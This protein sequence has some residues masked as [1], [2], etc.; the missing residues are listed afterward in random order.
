ML[1][2]LQDARRTKDVDFATTASSVAEAVDDLLGLIEANL[3][4]Y[5]EYRFIRTSPILGDED[6]RDGIRLTFEPVFGGTKKMSW[7]NVDVVLSDIDIGEA[8][9]ITPAS[10]LDMPG[11]PAP[12]YAVYPVAGSVADKICATLALHNGME[13]S[14]I[15]DL[16]DLSL[17]LLSCEID[18]AA[19]TRHLF[20]EF[21]LRKMEVP[22]AFE[23]PTGWYGERAR[24][25][26][27]KNAADANLPA[28]LRNVEDARQLVKR[29]ADPVLAGEVDGK[30][31][32]PET[33]EWEVKP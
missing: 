29:F 25:A 1:A 14:R 13:S 31:W 19:A 10:R 9:I 17:Y 4:D 20:R 11:L 24:A 8:D 3:S 26:F 5:L 23:I 22:S 32:N 16:V 28:P 21:R 7:F 6:Y 33:L 27:S 18:G 15:K 12:D 2:R 30:I